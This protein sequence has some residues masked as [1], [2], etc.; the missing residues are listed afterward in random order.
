MLRFPQNGRRR[1][2]A[3]AQ[4]T[5]A[6][7]IESPDRCGSAASQRHSFTMPPT[8]YRPAQDEQPA[9]Q[10]PL[11]CWTA[12]AQI[13]IHRQ[14]RRADLTLPVKHIKSHLRRPLQYKSLP[15]LCAKNPRTAYSLPS[16]DASSLVRRPC[17]DAPAR[18]GRGGVRRERRRRSRRTRYRV[19]PSRTRSIFSPQ[20]SAS[21]RLFPIASLPKLQ[22]PDACGASLPID[23]EIP[24]NAG[25]ALHSGGFDPYCYCPFL[26]IRFRS[27]R[28]RRRFF[29]CPLVSVPLPA[30]C[31]KP[32]GQSS[33]H[34]LIRQCRYSVVLLLLCRL[35]SSVSALNLL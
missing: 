33:P 8:A 13:P 30:F 1:K 6:A 5:L 32:R 35:F 15:F 18:L 28:H 9:A 20:R 27:C 7:C 4:H 16:P 17:Q 10:R 25:I 23:I 12:A 3:P 19:Y 11:G 34:R 29:D 31:P 14:I 21:F 26:Q 22:A 24:P 2:N